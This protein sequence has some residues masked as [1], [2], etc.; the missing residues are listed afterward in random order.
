MA[1]LNYCTGDCAVIMDD[2]FQNPPKEV[3]RLVDGLRE[4]YDVAFSYYEKKQHHVIRNLGSHFNN[5]VASALIGKPKDLY[6]SSFKAISRFVIDE[7]K[8]YSG[9]YPYIDG[10][11][12]RATR[13]YTTVQVHHDKRIE[14]RSGYTFRKLVS[15]WLNMFTNFSIMPLR[16][17][18][19]VGFF[20]ALISA[21]VAIVFAIE[22]LRNPDLPVGWASLIVSVFLIGS[23]QMFAIGMIGEYVGRLFSKQAEIPSLLCVLRSTAARMENSH[24]SGGGG[25]LQW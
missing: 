12:L 3:I 18:T 14:G 8:K 5:L 25:T 6:L 15:L 22:K 17:A 23:V 11:I 4:G 9:P 19:I 24:E 13:R 10:L 7:I 21:A 2:D 20:F 16:I 1:G